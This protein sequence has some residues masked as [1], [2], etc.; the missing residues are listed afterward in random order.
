MK[1]ATRNY[2]RVMDAEMRLEKEIERMERGI[3]PYNSNKLEKM[4]KDLQAYTEK[5]SELDN[6]IEESEYYE[7]LES[8]FGMEYWDFLGYNS[9]EALREAQ[10]TI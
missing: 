6:T 2:I 3:S 8:I 10:K 9:E 7:H 5:R 1:L 4:N